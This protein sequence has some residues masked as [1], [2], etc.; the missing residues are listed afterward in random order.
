MNVSSR[1]AW[2]F[3]CYLILLV[4]FVESFKVE[5]RLYR[6]GYLE[7]LPTIRKDFIHIHIQ[8]IPLRTQI[9]KYSYLDF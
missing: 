3:M 8:K 1:A 2:K 5:L 4:K 9:Y 6:F 7:D